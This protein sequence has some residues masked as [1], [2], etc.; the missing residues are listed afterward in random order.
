MNP[1]SEALSASGAASDESTRRAPFSVVGIGA[2]AG[3]LEAL[4]QLLQALPP[5]TG[6][7]FVIVQHLAPAHPSALAEILSRATTMPVLE[8][9]DERRVRPN[10]VFVIPPGRT[11]TIAHGALHLLARETHGPPRPIDQFF[12]S[13]AEEQAHQAIGVVL[14]GTATDG[15]LGLEAIKAEG[16][17]TFAQNETAQHASMPRS[18]IAAGCVDFVLPPH[19]I[20]QEI[21]RIAR[22]PYVQ[23]A[24]TAASPAAAA[25]A[26][27]LHVLRRE[28]GVD[29][30]QYKANTLSRRIT[31]RVVLHR[32]ADLHEY[33]HLLEGNPPEVAALY[34][35][36]LI[37]VTS[38]FRD[39]D[40]FAALQDSVMAR[41]VRGRLPNDPLRVWVLG[42]S[43]G[44]EAYSLAI[45]LSEAAETADVPTTF[46]VFATD[47]SAPPSRRLEPACTRSPS[48]RTCPPSGSTDSSSTSTATIASSRPSGTGASSR[49][50]TC[51]SIRRFP[52]ST[53]SAAG[54]SSS[55]WSRRFSSRS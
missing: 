9:H 6:L 38:F 48:S 36:I 51:S 50:T 44:E 54:T 27:I 12:Q 2:S 35:D 25:L 23:T 31:R 15:T 1:P 29:F 42:C 17:I 7:A 16:G 34:Q 4:R 53:S 13:L 5:D 28:T 39:P 45:A 47:L 46:Q 41:L 19:E 26:R 30:S 8:V 40:A 55:I 14:S 37:G 52:A 20:A 21:A 22:H 43:T 24:A 11:M 33:R 49:A 3:G 32:L 18:A 10:H